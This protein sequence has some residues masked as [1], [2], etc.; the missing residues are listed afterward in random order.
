[1]DK[2]EKNN[3]KISSALSLAWELG[4]TI[5]I[6]LV[7]FALIGRFLDKNLGTSPWLLLVGIILSIIISTFAIY[8]KAVKIIKETEQESKKK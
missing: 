7:V 3:Q 4:Y 6:P 8:Y 1:M 2:N 5:A